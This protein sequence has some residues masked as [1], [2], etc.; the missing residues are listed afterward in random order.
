M[1][2]TMTMTMVMLL[3]LF[4]KEVAFYTGYYIAMCDSVAR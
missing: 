4:G 3:F 2:M 1:T